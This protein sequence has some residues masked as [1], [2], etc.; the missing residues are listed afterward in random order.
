VAIEG[1][2]V[3]VGS[4]FDDDLGE[5]SGSVYVFQ[6]AGSGWNQVAKLLAHDA[7]EEARFGCSVAISENRVVVGAELDRNNGTESRSNR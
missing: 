4:E 3:I 7:E 2:T 5:D 1:D 6:D